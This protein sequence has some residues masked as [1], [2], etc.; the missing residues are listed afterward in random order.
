MLDTS[1]YNYKYSL[2]FLNFTFMI[3]VTPQLTETF[4]LLFQYFII[5]DKYIYSCLLLLNTFFGN[6]QAKR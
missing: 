6:F 2:M 1:T 3:I 5:M 4:L